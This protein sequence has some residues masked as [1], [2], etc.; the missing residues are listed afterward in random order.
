MGGS[1]DPAI[2][3]TSNLIMLCHE[4]HL[5]GVEIERAQAYRD[6]FLLFAGDDPAKIP[7]K[8]Y[9]LGYVHLTSDG[10]YSVTPPCD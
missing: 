7:V 9:A 2:N 4:C 5:G 8:V 10:R 1:Q 3:L 6:G